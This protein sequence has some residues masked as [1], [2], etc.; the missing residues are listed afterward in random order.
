MK[1]RPSWEEINDPDFVY[2]CRTEMNLLFNLMRNGFVEDKDLY[3]TLTQLADLCDC[4]EE[5]IREQLYALASHGYLSTLP[6]YETEYFQLR[7]TDT[8]NRLFGLR[9]V[10]P[11]SSLV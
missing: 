6:L 11:F 2:P 1:H 4:D 9:P 7:L 8:V 3:M 5:V 10:N